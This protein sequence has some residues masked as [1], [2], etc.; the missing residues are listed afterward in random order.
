MSTVVSV[1][2]WSAGVALYDAQLISISPGVGGS[3]IV[4]FST[5]DGPWVNAPGNP[6]AQAF[7][8]GAPDGYSVMRATAVGVA[9]SVDAYSAPLVGVGEVQAVPANVLTAATT[10][11][12]TFGLVSTVDG[13]PIP[14]KCAGLLLDGDS[15]A[16]Q[17][18][19]A[20]PITS[21]SQ[22]GG[23]ATVTATS[24]LPAVGS[25]LK[26]GNYA[27]PLWNGFFTCLT[28]SGGT[29][30]F[31]ISPAASAIPSLG[32][33]SQATIAAD[34]QRT[35]S[36]DYI[37]A[38]M[39]N[40]VNYTF[41]DNVA[42]GGRV[43]T[44][45]LA[46]S[47][48]TIGNYRNCL[49]DF[50]GGTNDPKNAVA[51]AT[52]SAAL[53]AYIVYARS[54]GHVVLLNTVPF[55]GSSANTAAIRLATLSLNKE[56]KRL[57]L[58]Y[59]C[60][61]YDKFAALCDPAA[62]NSLAAN[63]DSSDGIHLTPTGAKINGA[64]KAPIYAAFLPTRPVNLPA[65][66][67]DTIGTN[68]TSMNIMDG[69]FAGTGG[70]GGAGSIATGWT[71]APTTITVTGSKGSGAVGATQILTLSVASGSF[72]FTGTSVHA[73][74]VA[75]GV[76]EFVGKISL[77]NFAAGLRVTVEVLNTINGNSNGSFRPLATRSSTTP[78]PTA[79]GTMVFRSEPLTIPAGAAVT[80]FTPKLTAV[81][82]GVP[83]GTE[84]VTL[85][86]WAINRIA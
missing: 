50:N 55:L 41:M 74:V 7:V 27:D 82:T 25:R 30:T 45:I 16:E 66:T 20:L 35:A 60:P 29:V 77:A 51:L 64:A 34:T 1:G 49:I 6:Y 11:S 57:A 71:L 18:W 15:L 85:E 47:P 9:G 80:V 61:L 23:I 33:R 44:E 62:S 19:N 65:T 56:Y 22:V 58:K 75:G 68:S 86:N 21:A 79:N 43:L 13:A 3:I 17:N 8:G 40:G 73:N 72:T 69:F 10:A 70:S 28:E 78:L 37:W 54:L 2:V 59:G 53:E 76:Y 26:I 52:S 48:S 67:T 81:T 84:T 24:L 36:G 5:V 46:D 12:A 83:G 38:E 42:Y 39:L 31:A 63:I 4:Q 32:T 14:G